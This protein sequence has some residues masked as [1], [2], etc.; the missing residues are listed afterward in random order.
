MLKIGAM[1]ESFRQPFRQSVKLAAQ[2]GAQG[3]QAAA[4]GQTIHP[5]MSAAE[6][7]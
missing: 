2:S 6:L 3:I 1:V 5:G 7:A 4:F